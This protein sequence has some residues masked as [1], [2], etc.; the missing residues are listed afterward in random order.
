MN[1]LYISYWSINDPLTVATVYPNLKVLSNFDWIDQIV[2][3]NI[4]REV[5]VRQDVEIISDK[6]VYHPYNSQR[7]NGFLIEK[8]SDFTAGPKFI[9]KLV[10]QYK[11]NSII[12]RGAPAGALAYLVWRKTKT[13]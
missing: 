13:P 1:V 12:S 6:I 8:F 10:H 7:E 5:P 9:T 11:I 3:V 2:F 4:Q